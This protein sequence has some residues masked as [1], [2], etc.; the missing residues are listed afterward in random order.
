MNIFID[1]LKPLLEGERSNERIG[2]ALDAA[3]AF[4]MLQERKQ[5]NSSNTQEQIEQAYAEKVNRL[6]KQ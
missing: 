4:G 3:V 6:R 5:G 2:I 1:V